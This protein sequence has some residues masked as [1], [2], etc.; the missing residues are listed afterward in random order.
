MSITE[1]ELAKFTLY[2]LLCLYSSMGMFINEFKYITVI[3]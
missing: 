2:Q 3:Y 1:K